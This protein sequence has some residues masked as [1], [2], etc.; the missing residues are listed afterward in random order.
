MFTLGSGP[1]HDAQM[2][3]EDEVVA[4]RQRAWCPVQPVLP[5]QERLRQPV[6]EGWTL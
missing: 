5:D 1:Q 2:I 3:G 6:G 4:Q